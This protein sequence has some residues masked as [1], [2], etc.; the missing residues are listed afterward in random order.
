VIKNIKAMTLACYLSMLFM[1]VASSLI[2]SAARNIGLSPFQI[3]LMIAIQNVGFAI[4]VSISGALADS[5]E[6]TRVL[7]FG[8]LVLAVAF[9]TFYLSQIF[10]VNLV[11]ML[12][13][14]VGIGT[15]EGVTDAMLLDMHTDRAGLHINVNHFFVTLGSI[16]IALYLIFLEL[17]WRL[18]IIQSGIVVLILAMFFGLAR[19]AKRGG[20]QAGYRQ[21]FQ[22]LAKEKT[23]VVLFVGVMMVVGV[24]AG[25][26]GILSTFLA[27]LRGF[28]ALVCRLGLIVFLAGMAAGRLLIGYLT[29]RGSLSRYILGLFGLAVVLFAA[30]YLLD[31][32]SLTFVLIFLAGG[33]LSALLPLMLTLTGLRYREMS[34]TALGTLKVAIPIGGIL[35]P[36]LMSVLAQSTSLQIALLIY[37]AAFLVGLVLLLGTGS[38]K[39]AVGG[40]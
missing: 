20:Q 30:L 9:L 6:K 13:I 40:T 23:L 3:G 25:S 22:I 24:E 21:K 7:L 37:P 2:G 34:G 18:A 32:G 19:L 12:F 26:I 14:G 4:S 11:V 33:S 39:P 31:L 16:V 15:Y 1:G 5:H 17:N 27:E 29:R 28:S 36:F 35:L 38:L 10:W 8:S